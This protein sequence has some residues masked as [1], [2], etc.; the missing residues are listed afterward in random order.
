[1]K[2][3]ALVEQYV[4][5][6]RSL[7]M[8]FRSPAVRLKAFLAEIGDVKMNDITRNQ[9]LKFL[10]GKLG[11]TTS[12][13]FAK[14]QTLRTFFRYAIDRGYLQACPLPR[15]LPKKPPKFKPYIYTVAEVKR[16]LDAADSRHQSVWLLDPH[17]ARTMIL[18]L[19]GRLQ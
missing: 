7:G 15:T 11:P 18:L 13:W 9:V 5:H 4:E 19:Y 17:T 14:Y 2:L 8:V 10:D 6:K 16:L 12:F 3:G 1:M